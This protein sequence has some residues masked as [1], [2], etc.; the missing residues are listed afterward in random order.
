[1]TLEPVFAPGRPA[2]VDAAE[3]PPVSVADWIGEH[4]E[5][6][7]SLLRTHGA[8]R[9]TGLPVRT[10]AHLAAVRDALGARPA[11]AQEQFAP[12]AEVGPGVYSSPDWPTDRE[13]CLHHE[14]SYGLDFPGLLALACLTA[15]VSGGATLLGDTRLLL[16]VLPEALATRFRDE[17]WRLV[18]NFRPYLGV[19]WATAFGPTDPVAVEELCRQRLIGVDWLRDGTLH[20]TQRRSAVVHH[21]VT[22]EACW[23]NQAAFFS[24]WSVDKVERDVMLASFGVE[25]LPLNTTYG[26]GEQLMEEEFNTILEAYDQVMLRVPW[27]VGDLLLLDNVLMAHGREPYQ[28]ERE[29]AVAMGDP[30]ALADCS[31]T[32]PPTP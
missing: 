5:E 22:G 21:P 28:G 26:G 4:G 18:R 9:V 19:S 13:M 27:Q 14:Q 31:P 23:F 10:A 6:L 16:R 1:V 15:P 7:R 25:G 3:A 17:G 30:V 32:V 11:R 8:V 24:Q 20:T 2:T 12:R 29:I